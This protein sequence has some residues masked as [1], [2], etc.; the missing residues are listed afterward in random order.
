MRL[1]RLRKTGW[2]SECFLPLRIRVG[3]S[4]SCRATDSCFTPTACWRRAGN[5]EEFGEARLLEYFRK[6][7]GAEQLCDSVSSAVKDW[8]GGIA[9]DDITLVAMQFA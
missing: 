4:E 8:A 9:G 7:T 1:S 6:S 5:Q 3:A 2:C